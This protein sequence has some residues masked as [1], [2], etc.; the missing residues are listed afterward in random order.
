MATSRCH[1]CEKFLVREKVTDGAHWAL[2]WTDLQAPSGLGGTRTSGQDGWP[3][4]TWQRGSRVAV[5]QDKGFTGPCEQTGR[6]PPP[7]WPRSVPR[8]GRLRT[9][10]SELSTVLGS[11]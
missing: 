4:G 7:V 5:L 3:P 2:A 6:R 1:L 9:V 11:Q 8:A 10:V